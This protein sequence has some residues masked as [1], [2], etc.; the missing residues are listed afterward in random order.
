[1]LL[2]WVFARVFLSV[3]SWAV[4]CVF[5][6]VFGWVLGCVLDLLGLLRGCAAEIFGDTGERRASE[7]VIELC[8]VCEV[9]ECYIEK[10]Q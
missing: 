7:M 3:F 2:G 10:S 4:A 6:P 5:I 1:M 8:L 9:F